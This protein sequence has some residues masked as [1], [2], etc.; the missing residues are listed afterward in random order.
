MR[1][2]SAR[3]LVLICDNATKKSIFD[4]NQHVAQYNTRLPE[5]LAATC[6]DDSGGLVIGINPNPD[7]EK[8]KEKQLQKENQL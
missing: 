6:G 8:L 5:N 3:E 7:K 1:W 4:C 2:L